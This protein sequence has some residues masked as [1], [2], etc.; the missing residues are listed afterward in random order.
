MLEATGTKKFEIKVNGE[1]FFA[2]VQLVDAV[3][4]LRIAFSGN[5]IGM[6]PDKTGDVLRVR[7]SNETFV[8][9]QT[10]DLDKYNVFRAVPKEGVPYA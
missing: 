1:P 2:E 4:L 3:V 6:D 8:S 5:A 9:A 10:V 7:G